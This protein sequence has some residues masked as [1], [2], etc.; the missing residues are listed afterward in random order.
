M[1]LQVKSV[2]QARLG[3]IEGYRLTL[4]KGMGWAF[5][6][7]PVTVVPKVMA[8]GSFNPNAAG[9][10]HAGSWVI[11]MPSLLDSPDGFMDF[12][13]PRPSMTIIDTDVDLTGQ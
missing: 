8:L 3:G 12:L 6:A 2:K 13:G 1:H 4:T 7:K 10:F 5:K 11:Y 9:F